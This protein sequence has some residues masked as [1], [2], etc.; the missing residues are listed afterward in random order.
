MIDSGVV[1]GSTMSLTPEPLQ[2]IGGLR[3]A[4]RGAARRACGRAGRSRLGDE[5][6]SAE[7][8]RGFDRALEAL[9]EGGVLRG[10]G[11]GT[12]G[13]ATMPVT[14][15]PVSFTAACSAPMSLLVQSQNSIPSR[16]A[17][18]AARTRS[19]KSPTSAN[20]HSMQAE[21]FMAVSGSAIVDEDLEDVGRPWSSRR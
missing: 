9:E 4:R 14:A 19:G 17:F 1:S 20:G 5:R 7:A 13:S 3:Q 10:V 6:G 8:L 11:G 2:H 18:L 21:Y 12:I 15:I 16:P